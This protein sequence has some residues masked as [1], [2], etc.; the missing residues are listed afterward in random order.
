MPRPARSSS[1]TVRASDVTYEVAPE[2]HL[3]Y[4]PLLAILGLVAYVNNRIALS[5]PQL[6]KTVAWYQIFVAGVAVLFRRA[7]LDNLASVVAPA[8]LAVYTLGLSQITY[9]DAAVA[10]FGYYLCERLEGPFWAWVATLA[11]AIYAGYPA[12]WYV[13]ASALLAGT[14]LVRGGQNNKVPLAPIPVLAAAGY[15]AWQD[16]LPQ[17]TIALLIGQIVA[18]GLKYA[19]AV[20]D[21]S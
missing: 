20:S 3:D 10:L 5:A 9:I 21:S 17:F 19:E 6:L 14:R 2:G 7:Q 4:A 15:S 13:A 16:L 18:S 8:I 11:G 1:V 12:H